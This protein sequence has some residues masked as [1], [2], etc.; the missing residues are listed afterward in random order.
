MCEGFVD[1]IFSDEKYLSRKF[2][3]FE[4][5]KKRLPIKLGLKRVNEHNKNAILQRE[6]YEYEYF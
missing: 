1:S 4:F 2:Y 5:D 6:T 3:V